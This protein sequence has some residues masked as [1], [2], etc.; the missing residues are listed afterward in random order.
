MTTPSL[1]PKLAAGAFFG[2]ACHTVA[3]P[4]FQFAALH[5]IV[6]EREVPVH[7]HETPHFIVVTNGIYITQARNQSGPCSTDTLI[8]NPAGTTHRDRFR[9]EKGTF[10]SISPGP[11][12]S[13]FLDRASPI[14][15]AMAGKQSCSRD[16]SL[17]ATRIVSELRRRSEFSAAVLE[18]LGLELIGLSAGTE[19]RTASS[20]APYW[21]V[22]VKEMI[23]DCAGQ[24]LSIA[25][26]ALSVGVHPVYLARSYRRYFR[27]SPGEYSRRRRLLRAQE[28][29]SRTDLPLVEI[30]LRC[31]FADQSQM[32]RSFSAAFGIAP[33]RY[34]RRL[35]SSLPRQV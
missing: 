7:T 31:G 32:T 22:R 17:I 6:A 23:E 35:C 28:L 8:F 12:V 18:S 14:S 24:D 15:V 2:D 10:V 1:V 4:S 5:A 30:A 34:R 11:S 26:L 13:R 16:D 3:T 33:A 29:V 19:D 9:G 20:T 27:C 21:L 25:D